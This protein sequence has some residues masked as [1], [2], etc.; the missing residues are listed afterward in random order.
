MHKE[1]LI[2]YLKNYKTYFSSRFEDNERVFQ[3]INRL[4][5]HLKIGK[6]VKNSKLL[7]VGSGDKSF[8]EVCMQKGVIV[9]EIDGVREGINFEKDNLPFE[10]N[11]YDFVFFCAVIEHLND[12][13]LILSEI[14]RVLKKGGTLIVITPNFAYCY[15]EFYNDPTHLHPYTP[16]SLRKILEMNQFSKNIVNP[17]LVNKPKFFWKIPKKFL[18]ASILPFRNDSFINLPI[19]ELFRGRSTSMI[20]VSK[21]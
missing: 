3:T 9:E 15:R 11:S 12:S 20:S 1:K 16:Q 13:N 4:L 5:D 14:Y 10:S 21:K 6:I 18:I 2:S 19:P 17:F 8:Y 7:D